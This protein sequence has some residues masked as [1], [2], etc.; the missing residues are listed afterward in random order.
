MDFKPWRNGICWRLAA[1]LALSLVMAWVLVAQQWWITFSILLIAFFA[2]AWHLLWYVQRHIQHMHSF[3]QAL[4]HNDLQ[5]QFS[6]RKQGLGLEK[7]HSIFNTLQNRLRQENTQQNRDWQFF[8]LLLNKIE[9]GIIAYEVGDNLLVFNRAASKHLHVSEGLKLD[10]LQQLLPN[11]WSQWQ[12]LF[13]RGGGTTVFTNSQNESLAIAVHR[14][15]VRHAIYGIVLIQNVQ[16]SH[17]DREMKAWNHL[18]KTLTHEMMNTIT[19]VVSLSQSLQG[20]L[21]QPEQQD[22]VMMGLQSIENRSEALLHFAQDYRKLLQIPSPQLQLQSVNEWL[23]QVLALHRPQLAEAAIDLI[24]AKPD[25]PIKA[26][27]DEAQL[28]RA[29]GNVLQNAKEALNE[30]PNATISVGVHIESNAWCISVTDNG[31]G[32]VPAQMGEIFV[33]FFSTKD[34]GSGIGLSLARQLVHQHGGRLQAENV[35]SGGAIFTFRMPL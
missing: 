5:Q 33:P 20:L 34:Q 23:E 4:L 13:E 22:K 14:M 30:T 31:P 15:Q 11:F 2:L 18:I 26:R 25:M 21:Q 9:V 32:I 6:E 3:T 35:P 7:L 29:L 12:S 19:P 28:D 17:D 27:F 8:R 10:Q 24:Y 1:L 16:R